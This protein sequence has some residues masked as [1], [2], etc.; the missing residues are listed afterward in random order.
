MA[1]D[2]V[3]RRKIIDTSSDSWGPFGVPNS[4]QLAM[5]AG[6]EPG[7]MPA[8]PFPDPP[9]V[10]VE[11][12]ERILVVPG[13]WPATS[14]QVLTDCLDTGGRYS[15]GLAQVIFYADTSLTSTQEYTLTLET[16][17]L[18]EE[19]AFTDVIDIATINSTNTVSSGDVLSVW[20]G[21]F[22]E[23]NSDPV[24]RYLRWRLVQTDSP[25]QN[26]FFSVRVF[27]KNHR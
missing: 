6:W 21:I 26:L 2:K 4:S 13:D 10:T 19:T 15:G 14:S 23:A 9:P 3:G 8:P 17:P 22:D 12:Q 20:F 25:S 24:A 18:L 1:V 11:L 27:L 16:A 7:P 5:A